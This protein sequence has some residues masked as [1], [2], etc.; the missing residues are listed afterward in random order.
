MLVFVIPYSDFGKIKKP[1]TFFVA[2]IYSLSVTLTFV[3]YQN[4]FYLVNAGFLILATLSS[5]MI[6]P[7]SNSYIIKI[8][9]FYD[10]PSSKTNSISFNGN[11]FGYAGV[12]LLLPLIL[13][14]FIYLD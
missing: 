9:N 4:Q 2:F 11:A 13:I 6:S 12:A 5:N 14:I 1:M 3:F 7:M 8:S 10:N